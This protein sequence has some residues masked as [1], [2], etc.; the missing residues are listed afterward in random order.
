MPATLPTPRQKTSARLYAVQGVY[1]MLVAGQTAFQVVQ[2]HAENRGPAI[3]DMVDLETPDPE[4][5]R[6]IVG[7][8]ERK[9]IELLPV[10]GQHLKEGKTVAAMRDQ[11]PLLLAIL[12]CA[13]YELMTHLDIDAPIIMNDYIDVTQSYYEG[14]ESSFVNGILDRFKTLYRP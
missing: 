8:V 6:A 3:P 5:F 10:L 12:M 13:A 9:S 2:A 1:Q 11:E 7:G 14:N 4:L